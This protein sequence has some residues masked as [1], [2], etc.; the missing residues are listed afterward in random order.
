MKKQ[1]LCVDVYGKLHR[2]HRRRRSRRS[3]NC[4]LVHRSRSL[5][6][7]RRERERERSPMH[8]GSSVSDELEFVSHPHRLSSAH[9]RGTR[10]CY[11]RLIHAIDSARAPPPSA[12]RSGPRTPHT[13]NVNNGPAFLCFAVVARKY[14]HYK[15]T[16]ARGGP[17][18]A[19]SMACC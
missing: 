8:M 5:A 14:L 9:D 11:A 17:S 4:S 16:Q 12:S 13:R 3:P 15:S 19:R 10:V 18:R 2:K 6:S 7:W 1:H